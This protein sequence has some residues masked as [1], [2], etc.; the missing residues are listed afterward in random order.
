MRTRKSKGVT[1][2]ELLIAIT[3]IAILGAIAYPSYQDHLRKSRRAEGKGALLKA[4]QVLERWYTD[5]N[6]YG[7]TPPPPAVPASIDLVPLF[8]P[9][10]VVVYSGENP[11]D[12]RGYYQIT[13][14]AATG[15]CP[16]VSCFLLT[17]TPNAPFTDAECGNFTLTSTGVR[18][19]S[20][21]GTPATTCSPNP[22]NAARCR[23]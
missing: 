22:A 16:L 8:P 19:W 5:R 4:A 21:S 20:T 9:A 1:L 2:I 23:W 12:N 17:A 15:A 6:S 7:N 14:A 10:A 11:A 18:C 13:A 3:V